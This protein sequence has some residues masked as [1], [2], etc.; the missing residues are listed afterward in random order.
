MFF[1]L[2]YIFVLE[3][4]KEFVFILRLLIEFP[5]GG[6]RRRECSSQGNVWEMRWGVWKQ[7]QG[8]APKS[9]FGS[10][11]MRELSILCVKHSIERNVVGGGIKG[12]LMEGGVGNFYSHEDWFLWAICIEAHHDHFFHGIWCV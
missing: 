10:L 3:S 11:R 8:P 5:D 4:I 9:S 1:S 12:E 2:T 7:L 6:V